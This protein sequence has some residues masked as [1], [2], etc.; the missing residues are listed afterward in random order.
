MKIVFFFSV[1]WILSFEVFFKNSPELFKN[2]SVIA[3]VTLKFSYSLISATIFYFIAVHMNDF[4]SRKK[5]KPVIYEN[6]KQLV[7]LKNHLLDEMYFVAVTRNN[8]Q[9]NYPKSYK[10]FLESYYPSSDEVRNILENI[11]PYRTRSN[12]NNWFLR[13][14]LFC[15]QIIPHIET[16]FLFSNHFKAEELAIMA[17]IR[18]LTIH[19]KS[20]YYLS[21]TSNGITIDNENLA[22]LFTEIDEMLSTFEELERLKWD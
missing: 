5:V 17:R 15:K 19:S 1:I 4:F 8:G 9:V 16:I 14:D 10:G 3:E 21:E 7:E 22:F 6:V 11:P 20:A 18:S 13:L 2:A 12:S